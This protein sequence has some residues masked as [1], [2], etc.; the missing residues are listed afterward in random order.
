MGPRTYRGLRASSYYQIDYYSLVY[1][2]Y[3]LFLGKDGD[4]I[5]NF[6]LHKCLHLCSRYAAIA[7]LNFFV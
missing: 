5:R 4:N 3:I 7:S 1:V 2:V 6:N